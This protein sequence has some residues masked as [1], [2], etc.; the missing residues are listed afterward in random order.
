MRILTIRL[1]SL[2]LA[3]VACKPNNVGQ[4]DAT[5]TPTQREAIADT[6]R[7]LTS[8]FFGAMQ[9]VDADKAASF[10]TSSPDYTFL[11]E[12]GGVCRTPETCQ[13]LNKEGWQSVKS[14]QIRVID[15]KVAV[16]SPTVAVETMT[17]G[18]S[19]F[20]KSGKTIVVDKAA[21]TIV[22]VREAGGWKMLTFHQSF[23]PPNPRS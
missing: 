13:K 18:G 23:P 3:M 21:I 8:D 10:A 2:A 5:V 17:I 4:A 1:L 20:P 11:S 12:D 15:S 6:V 9:S 19:I 7:N 22:W 14:M 16:V